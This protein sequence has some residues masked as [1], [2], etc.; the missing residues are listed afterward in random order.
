MQQVVLVRGDVPRYFSSMGHRRWSG[1]GGAHRQVCDC[2]RGVRALVSA[3]LLGPIVLGAG[4]CMEPIDTTRHVSR[5]GS[6]G[7]DMYGA[8]CDRLGAGAFTED[9][10]GASYRSLCHADKQGVFGDFVDASV[11]PT[12]ESEAGQAA[13]ALSIAKLER[14]AQRRSALIAAF[15]GVFPDITVPDLST[16]D[17]DD[18]VRLHD[19]LLEFSGDVTALY[20]IDPMN[21]AVEPVMPMATRALGQLV[22]SLEASIDARAALGRMAGRQGYRPFQAALGAIRV[23]LAYPQLRPLARALLPLLEPD[24]A[25]GPALQRALA[26]LQGKLANVTPELS[27]LPPLVVDGSTAQPNRPREAIELLAD[28]A[29]EEDDTYRRYP[30]PVPRYVAARDR[31]GFAIPAGNVPG[32]PGTVPPPFADLDGDGHADVDGRG[33]FTDGASQPLSVDSPFF[34]PGT[35]AGPVDEYGRPTAGLY[36]YL[37]TSRTLVASLAH[38]LLALADPSVLAAP[39]DPEPWKVEREALMYAFEGVPVLAGPREAAQYDF[40][41]DARVPLD[42]AC[43]QCLQY[44]RFRGEDSPLADLVHALGQL[45][46][47]PDSDVVLEALDQLLASNEAVVARTVGALLRTKEISDEHDERA[48]QGLEL[49]AEVAYENPLYDEMAQV[50]GEMTREPRLIAALVDVLADPTLVDRY[51][52]RPDLPAA[53]ADWK[54]GD[55]MHGFMTMRDV[56]HYDRSDLN[57]ATINVTDGGGSKSNPHNP[58]DRT[59]PLRGDNRSMFERTLQMIYDTFGAKSCNK[60]DAYVYTGM[61]DVYWPLVGE[62]YLECELLEIPNMGAYYFASTL[63][64]GHPKRAYLNIK[65]DTLQEI[66]GYLG[67]VESQDAFLEMA[68]GITG[69]TLHPTPEALNRQLMFGGRSDLYGE[70]PDFDPVNELTNTGKF[71]S[72]SMDAIGGTPCPLDGNAVPVCPSADDVIRIRDYGTSLGWE[73]IGFLYYTT[74]IAKAFA[75]PGCDAFDDDGTPTSCD[76]EDF[77]GESYY[78]R[79]AAILWRN[80]PDADHGPYCDP[81]G[82]SQTNLRYCSEAGLNHYEPIVADAMAEDLMPA[83]NG[84]GVALQNLSVTVKRGPKA[85]QTFS[86]RQM[87]EVLAKVLFDQQYAAS[88]GMVDRTGKAG[89]VW[90]D[91]TPQAQLTVFNLFA[92]ALHRMDTRFAQLCDCQ[93]LSGDA[94]TSCEQNRPACEAEAAARKSKWKRARSLVVD[95][96]LAVEGEGEQTRFVNRAVPYLLRAVIRVAREQLNAHCPEREAGVTCTWAKTELASKLS[97]VIS[98]P[99][100]AG[101]VDLVDAIAKDDAARRALGTLLSYALRDGTDAEALQGMLASV[102]DLVQLLQADADL[103]PIL[104]AAS[105]ALSP[106]ELSPSVLGVVDRA[107]TLVDRLSGDEY[108][109]YHVLDFVL[110]L[111]VTPMDGGQGRSPV[112]IMADAIA[113]IERVDARAEEPLDLADYEAVLRS[114]REF[115]TSDTRGFEQL[116]TIV[117]N[118]VRE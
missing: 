11:L 13:R 98:G 103:T 79:V 91:G 72:R 63:P 54:F 23:M 101:L 77:H 59:A 90:T 43:P 48:A 71:V 96:F 10:E 104:R 49:R 68:S 57:S 81:S 111:L 94:L 4:S 67:S 44:T 97:D 75:I 73:R 109:R 114:V 33:R 62:G 89:T 15:D 112:E 118:R 47:D 58:V 108:D 34:V 17:P 6:L 19:A 102:V 5:I 60:P 95:Q 78:G 92:D 25:A 53:P 93:G 83:L 8:L 116:Y 2:W 107:V 65:S 38:D 80:W 84:L 41:A 9:L 30:P 12:P 100:F 7:E 40:V 26:A 27:G 32:Q 22:G 16:P 55:T 76:P 14:M 31:R 74:P 36:Q 113:D 37:D 50:L 82:S 105:P 64:N 99:M 56:F 87:T 39:E 85:G 20:D 29:L 1:E 52:E 88:V 21:P 51:Q 70:L 61:G 3:A 45:L 24:G 117:Q 18:S 69:F 86:G 115:L 110:P 28:L 35:A 66:L 42:Q 106:R 46:A